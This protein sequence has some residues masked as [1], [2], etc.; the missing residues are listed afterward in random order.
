MS[1][2]YI[3]HLSLYRRLSCAL[4]AWQEDSALGRIRKSLSSYLTEQHMYIVHRMS[5]TKPV[6]THWRDILPNDNPFSTQHVN[7]STYSI[8]TL[9][10]RLSETI[11]I[12]LQVRMATL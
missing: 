8:P 4:G 5:Q 2:A 12:H 3:L 11:V 9:S 6:A 10:L 7:Y 1:S